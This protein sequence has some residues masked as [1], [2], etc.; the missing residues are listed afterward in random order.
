MLRIGR[1][2]VIFSISSYGGLSS[3]MIVDTPTIISAPDSSEISASGSN[4]FQKPRC[5][6]VRFD[7]VFKMQ[8]SFD[9]CPL[10]TK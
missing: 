8:F 9:V 7:L 6:C 5:G 2:L 4:P 3:D 1:V 10:V